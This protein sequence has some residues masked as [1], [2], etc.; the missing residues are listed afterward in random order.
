MLI[1]NR[2]EQDLQEKTIDPAAGKTSRRIPTG[3]RGH[4]LTG[5]LRE[6]RRDA[7]L[8]LYMEAHRKFGDVVRLRF[9]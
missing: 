7:L 2:R 4:L 5:R 8:R 6:V 3:V 9:C 1:I